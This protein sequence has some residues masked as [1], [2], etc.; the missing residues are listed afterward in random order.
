MATLAASL[1]FEAGCANNVD[2]NGQPV[3]TQTDRALLG[4]FGLLLKNKAPEVALTDPRRGIAM[5]NTG[6]LMTG[7]AVNMNVRNRSNNQD[8]YPVSGSSGA[9]GVNNAPPQLDPGVRKVLE[10]PYFAIN[11]IYDLNENGSL[12]IAGERWCADERTDFYLDSPAIATLNVVPYDGKKIKVVAEYK[13]GNDLIRDVIEERI[14]E[15][16]LQKGT[17]GRRERVGLIILGKMKRELKQ[18]GV[19]VPDIMDVKFFCYQEG[20]EEPIA[21]KDTR[22]HFRENIPMREIRDW[23]LLRN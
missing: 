23:T 3:Y 18:K 17:L 6:D 2:E 14:I 15:G 9:F 13:P 8:S 10:L 5:Y 21:V 20:D 7:A 16:K 1:S 4:I 22:F 12:D 19:N 11:T